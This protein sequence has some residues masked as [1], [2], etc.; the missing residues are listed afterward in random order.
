MLSSAYLGGDLTART[1]MPKEKQTDRSRSDREK[2]VLPFI[3]LFLL[4]CFVKVNLLKVSG[5]S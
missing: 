2:I 4:P 3:V 1:R 5:L